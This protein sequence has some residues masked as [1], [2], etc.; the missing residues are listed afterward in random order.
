MA[1]GADQPTGRIKREDADQILMAGLVAVSCRLFDD[2][3]METALH[4]IERALPLA[5]ASTR[6]ASFKPIATNLTRAA[7]LR[8]SP[9]GSARWAQVNMD[10]RQALARDALQQALRRVEV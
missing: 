8:R 9:V 1:D 10:L 6:M 5:S 7:M 4:L 2:T 3:D